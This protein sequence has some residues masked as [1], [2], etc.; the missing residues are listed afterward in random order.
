[1]LK[2][3]AAELREAGVKVKL[4]YAGRERDSWRKFIR[5]VPCRWLCLQD[6]RDESD[7]RTLYDLEY[8]PHLYLLDEDGTII[9]KDIRAI[10]L[11][12]LLPYL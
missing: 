8:V 5:S 11:K 12:E 2:S 7:M 1:M 9:A 10:E 3:L 4:V 6:F